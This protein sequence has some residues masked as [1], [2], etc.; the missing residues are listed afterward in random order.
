[1]AIDVSVDVRNTG[2]SDVNNA[3]LQMLINDI[4]VGQQLVSL[5]AGEEKSYSFRIREQKQC[6]TTGEFTRKIRIIYPGH[7]FQ[8][9]GVTSAVRNT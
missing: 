8:C 3:L 6:I 7:I 9:Y 2:T 5:T 4:N 1:M